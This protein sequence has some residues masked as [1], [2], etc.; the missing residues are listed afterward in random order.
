ME[1]SQTI[2]GHG[3]LIASLLLLINFYLASSSLPQGNRLPYMTSDVDEVS[4]KSFDYIVVGGGTAGCALAATLSEKFSVLLVER[5]GSPYGNPLV[6]DKRYYG[7]ALVETDE[8]TS[9]AQSFKCYV[10]SPQKICIKT[11]I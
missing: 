1:L 11:F 6:L 10:S 3:L 8:Y 9:V 5:G 2:H 7:F 4:G